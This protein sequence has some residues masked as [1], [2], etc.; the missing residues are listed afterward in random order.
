M[1]SVRGV[2]DHEP[3]ANMGSMSRGM[4]RRDSTRE[5]RRLSGASRTRT[6]NY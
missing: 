1:P 3:M 4:S 5:S 6:P 2:P